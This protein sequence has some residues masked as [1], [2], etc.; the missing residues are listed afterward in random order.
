MMPKPWER[1][2]PPLTEEESLLPYA[3]YYHRKTVPAAPQLWEQAANP[4]APD[5]AVPIQNINDLLLP[6]DGKP[7]RGWC[8]MPDGTGY[9]SGTFFWPNAT[10]EMLN[11]W[12]VWHGL[13]PLRYKVWEPSTHFDLKIPN[14]ADRERLLDESIPMAERLWGVF[15]APLEAIGPEPTPVMIQFVD[16]AEL[17]FDKS[18]FTPENCAAIFCATNEPATMVHLFKQV[19]G[20]LLHLS[21]FYFGYKCVGGTPQK[22]A[23]PPGALPGAV[24]GLC[25]HN[26]LEFTRLSQ[27]LPEIYEEFG[28]QNMI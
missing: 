23:T 9:A 6:Q 18:R 2:V 21:R 28:R 14:P 26:L 5:Q 7:E 22:C 20:G 17:G 12:F 13:E 19:P 10:P 1:P 4:I 25:M 15:H 16:P 24:I 11:W 3:K 27:I 8:L